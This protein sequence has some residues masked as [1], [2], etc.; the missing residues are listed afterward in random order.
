MEYRG[1]DVRV[2]RVLTTGRPFYC[3]EDRFW[4][5]LRNVVDPRAQLDVVAKTEIPVPL[6]YR[7]PD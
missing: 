3:R 2:L 1:G 6:R 4:Y 5:P 7:T